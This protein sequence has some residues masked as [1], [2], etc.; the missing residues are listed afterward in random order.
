MSNTFT[1]DQ[2]RAD[3]LYR[4]IIAI[5]K[6]GD[7]DTH[8]IMKK[9]GIPNSSLKSRLRR[10]ADRKIIEI[11]G[12]VQVSPKSRG[13]MNVWGL[14]E[15]SETPAKPNLPGR[16]RYVWEDLKRDPFSHWKLC[17]MGER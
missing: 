9:T 5:L 1:A 17:G 7:A 2:M 10:L 8:A 6:R 15:K 12:K 3:P 14:R 13:M 11:K 4:D 16:Y